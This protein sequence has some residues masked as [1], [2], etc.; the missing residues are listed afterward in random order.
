M[1]QP[2]ISWFWHLTIALSLS[3]GL[4]TS[5]FLSVGSIVPIW[6]TWWSSSCSVLKS[7]S[8]RRFSKRNENEIFGRRCEANLFFRALLYWDLSAF[9]HSL[10]NSAFRTIEG[11]FFKSMQYTVRQWFHNLKATASFRVNQQKSLLISDAIFRRADLILF[12]FCFPSRKSF[13]CS[14]LSFNTW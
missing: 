11:F 1:Q 6:L 12:A 14:V 5:I 4:P 8:S 3:A 10:G 2:S 9:I 13:R 7:D